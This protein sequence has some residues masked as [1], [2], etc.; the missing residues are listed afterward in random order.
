MLGEVLNLHKSPNNLKEIRENFEMLLETY[1][2]YDKFLDKLKKC[3]KANKHEI[4]AIENRMRDLAKQVDESAEIARK[5]AA[6]EYNKLT[7]FVNKVV[8]EKEAQ[9]GKHNG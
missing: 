5:A 6:E 8:K 2:S 7:V 4:S 3:S 9:R 1:I